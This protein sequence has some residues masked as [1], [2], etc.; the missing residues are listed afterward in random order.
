[1]SEASVHVVV[2]ED[3]N[4]VHYL[5]PLNVG[6]ILEDALLQSFI[7]DQ[8]NE[9]FL[10]EGSY[11]EDTVG[12]LPIGLRISAQSLLVAM[13]HAEDACWLRLFQQNVVNGKVG[14]LSG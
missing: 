10:P 9:Q 2:M 3:V 1:V 5:S 4:A 14:Y 13:L 8:Q 12:E 7:D 6:C 11:N